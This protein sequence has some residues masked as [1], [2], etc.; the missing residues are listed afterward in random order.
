MNTLFHIFC[1]FFLV[2]G[3]VATTSTSL[4]PIVVRGNAFF[5]N[6]TN[7]RF[8]IRGVDY[9]PGGSSN[10]TDPLADID[11]CQRDISYFKELGINAIRVYTVDNALNH[12][13]CMRLLDQ[14]GIYVILDL[15]TPKSSISRVNP[16]CSYNAYYLQN[17][18][19][20]V[21]AFVE[22]NNVLGFFAGNEVINNENTTVA[23]TYVKATI[24]DIKHY[25]KAR[26]YRHIPVGY[27]A[28]DIVS[29]RVLVAEYLNCGSDE[30][31][32][33]DMFGVN[34]YSWCGFSSFEQ[35]GYAEKMRLYRNYS[36]PM[37][38]SEFGCNKVVGPRPFTEI[39]ALYSSKMTS[40]FSGGL[41]YEYSEQVNNYGLVDI[42]GNN[43]TKLPDFENLKNEYQQFPNPTGDGGYSTSNNYS[44][45]P[46]Y[47]KGIWEANNTLPPMPSAASIYFKSGAGAPMG[48]DFATQEMCHDDD[49]NNEN[50]STITSSIYSVS[51]SFSKSSSA[52]K[53]HESKSKGSATNIKIPIFFRIVLQL[54][55]LIV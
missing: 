26:N 7:E 33:M 11:T 39:G 50:S 3:N 14:A 22:Y 27:A 35:S 15:N 13:G 16:A 34:D 29:N 5:N 9:Q 45:C 2:C 8:Y 10:L 18:F 19:A 52:S 24:R 12:S 4:P 41:V 28:A 48:T 43:V 42:H 46:D 17:V 37:F 32:R 55:N 6:E 47:V 25:L 49:D 51:T 38:L 53:S 20:T 40:V 31:A 30:Y 36:L 54:W 21:D 1:L 44:I 23:A